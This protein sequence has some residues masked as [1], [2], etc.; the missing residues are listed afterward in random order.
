[1]IRQ[2]VMNIWAKGDKINSTKGGNTIIKVLPALFFPI[3][4]IYMEFALRLLAKGVKFF[5]LSLLR[6]TLFSL[7]S[8]IAVYLIL[9]LIPAKI[10]SRILGGIVVFLG[11][12][13]YGIEYCC[14]DFYGMYFG[15]GYITGMS[16]KV[17]D[18]F[19]G[20]LFEVASARIPGILVFFIPVIIYAFFFTFIVRK[21]KNYPR[22]ILLI[23]ISFII[24]WLTGIILSFKGPDNNY[25]TYDYEPNLA[26]Q[27]YGVVDALFLEGEYALFGKPEIPLPEAQPGEPLFTVFEPPVIET[28]AP[29]TV[30][31]V[32]TDP[33]DV[34]SEPTPEPTPYPFNMTDIDFE[35]LY[36][37]TD[38]NTIKGMHLYF[39]NLMPT[40]QNEYTGMF[41]GKNLILIT[42]EAFSP[43]AIDKDYTPTLYKLA[44]EGFVFTDFYQPNWHLST[45]GGEYAVMTGQIP[46]WIGSYNSFYA[47]S[48]KY[49][50]YGLGTVFGNMG[51]NVPA[52]HDGDYTYYD[53]D[54]THPNLGYDYSAI[55]HGLNVPTLSWPAS[56]YEMFC[57]TVDSYVDECVNSGTPFHAYYMT[58][59]GHCNY[60]WGA[61]AMSKRNKESA[62]EAFPDSS[63]AVQAYMAANKELDLGLEYLLQRL[64]EAGIADDTVIVMAADHYPYG[65]SN[66]GIDHYDELSGIDDSEQDITRYRNTLILWCGSIEEPIVVDTPCSSVDIV[67]TILNLFGVEYDSRLFAGRD[68]FA[69]EYDV[70]QCINNMP[71]VI[72]PMNA[73]NSWVTSAGQ[74]DCKTK[75]FTPNPG[76]SVSDE[77]VDEVNQLVKDKVRY[78]GMMIQYDYFSYVFEEE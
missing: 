36:N 31:P 9:E 16:G 44:N 37:D 51:Y 27:R 3:Y 38:N 52:W 8:G 2:G 34:T 68:I 55:N 54:K 11:F 35:S 39:G 29:S 40:Q 46:Q 4:F 18:G 57:A 62:I 73:G 50:P 25:A 53:R 21:H 48:S 64:E 74:Y 42:A 56:D 20:T 14:M 26:I 23:F 6:I 76:I 17:V 77:Y 47:S 63:M 45:T 43:Y 49:M 75:T 65:L 30:N 66:D 15:L 67:P 69:P 1:M 60:S 70:T 61:N 22:I 71:L 24:L 58:V 19:S 32:S 72:L 5:E 10:I 41:E 33:S 13:L 59:S 12:I 78:S 7:V 28:S